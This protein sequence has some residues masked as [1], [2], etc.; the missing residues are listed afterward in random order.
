MIAALLERIPDA[1]LNGHPTRRLPNN[2]NFSFKYVE[3]E[4]IL[5][6]LDLLGVAASSGSA[7]STGSVE[8]SHVLTAI[9]IEPDEAFGSLRLTLGRDSTEA[10]V[11]YVAGILPPILERLRSISPLAEARA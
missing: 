7:C 1:R 9:G 6:Q 3:G 11:D 2:A 8:P 10:D 4:A 5:I